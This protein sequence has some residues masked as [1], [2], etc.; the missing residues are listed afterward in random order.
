MLIV[1]VPLGNKYVWVAGRVNVPV[2]SLVIVT[3]MNVPRSGS[4]NIPLCVMVSK[5]SL[6]LARTGASTSPLC[7][8]SSAPRCSRLGR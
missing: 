8:A 5:T 1:V 6:R 4:M 7:V 2:E 3:F